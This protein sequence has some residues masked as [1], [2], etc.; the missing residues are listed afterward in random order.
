MRQDLNWCAGKFVY[1]RGGSTLL[2]FMPLHSYALEYALDIS[3]I[4]ALRGERMSPS[5]PSLGDH[6]LSRWMDI[7]AV[8][9]IAKLVRAILPSLATDSR[10]AQI[11]E[12]HAG[13][14]VVFEVL[15]WAMT[16]DDEVRNFNYTAIGPESDRRKFQ[17]LHQDE[18]ILSYLSF[19]EFRDQEADLVIVNHLRAVRQGT[20]KLD[21]ERLLWHAR[22]AAIL[23]LHVI[24]GFS[25]CHRTTI[26]GHQVTLLPFDGVVA[27]CQRNSPHWRY[28]YIE[29]HDSGYFLPQTSPKLGLMLAYNAGLAIEMPRFRPL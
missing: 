3:L 12:Y 19:E 27:L 28:Q 24:E 2:H 6:E 21:L 9:E 17:T 22:G 23:A 1:A 8:E 14:G 13:L 10:P 20:D 15:R 29:G 4:L 11:I 7:M 5:K 25:E 26:N 18:Q 16:R